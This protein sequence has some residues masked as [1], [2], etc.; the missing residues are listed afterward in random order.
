MF[1]KNKKAFEMQFNWIFVL[2][3]GASIL[4]FFTAIAIKQKNVSEASSQITI[5]K[6]LLDEM[7][8]FFVA[9]NIPVVEHMLFD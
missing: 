5:F 7:Q 8:L 4:I 3:V 1:N 2:V 9:D 6:I